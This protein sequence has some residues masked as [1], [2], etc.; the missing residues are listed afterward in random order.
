MLSEKVIGT[1]VE[2]NYSYSWRDAALYN[3]SV[4]AR[5]DQLEYVYE[6]CLKVIPTFAAAACVATFGVEPHR[7]VPLMPTALLDLPAG[8][9]LHM[10]HRLELLRPLPA[11]GTFR[12]TK[13]IS[14]VYDRGDKG[15]KIEVTI[16]GG[17]EEG[18]AFRNTMG[19]LKMGCGNFG[20]RPAPHSD[21]TMPDRAPDV[22]VSGSYP[23]NT[24][25]LYRL[26]GDTFPL[27][28]DPEVS[29]KSGFAVPII[30]GMCS[31]GHAVRTVIDAVIPGEPERVTEIRNQFRAVALPGDSFRVLVWKEEGG[32]AYFRM[33]NP[34]G[35][36]IL[37]YG[38]LRYR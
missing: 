31:L 30:H 3:L 14:N 5:G 11:A 36:A 20:G 22:E 13:T 6:K 28:I 32:E 18:F 15:A 34:D 27:H 38:C 23:G 24:A 1:K 33:V 17:D 2:E 10:D 19:Y 9:F 35:K 4:G 8:G 25:A 7:D 37:D 29:K 21:M 12:I 16:E 26:T